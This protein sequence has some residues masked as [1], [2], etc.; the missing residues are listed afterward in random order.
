MR[1]A[2]A[3]FVVAMAVPAMAQLMPDLPIDATTRQ[4]V[5]EA[6]AQELKKSYVFA[7]VAERMVDALNRRASSGAY[8]NLKSSLAFAQQLTEDMQGVSHDKHLRL[9]YSYEAIPE[10]AAAK[11]S[12]E[13]LERRERLEREVNFGF[14]RA[15]RLEGNV[16]YLE[17]RMFAPS[18]SRAEE[19]ASAAMTFLAQTD[20][21]IIDLRRNH[22]GNPAM[23]AYLTSYLFDERTHLNDLHWRDPERIEEFW[24]RSDIPGRRFGSTKPVYVLTSHETFSG[25]EE[26]AYNLKSLKRA[27]I[28][29]ES[30]GG[31]AH[32][33][34]QRRVGQHFALWVPRGRAVNPITKTNWE[35][36]GV[37]PDVVVPAGD[38]LAKAKELALSALHRPG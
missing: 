12:P 3:F 34:G 33:G 6:C 19:V 36:T 16:G 1:L 37:A 11:P 18:S 17:L 9:F 22:G 26:F 25:G 4:A 14:E 29:G 38:A 8:D 15:E 32:P 30:T 23:I 7:D 24:T 5:I 31:G 20:A 13:M 2:L 27:T 21:L 35:G 10:R 28:V